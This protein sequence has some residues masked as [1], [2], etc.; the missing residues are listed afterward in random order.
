MIAW[1]E[2]AWIGSGLREWGDQL[3]SKSHDWI[4][5]PQGLS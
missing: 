3:I 1:L 5:L 4:R 2:F